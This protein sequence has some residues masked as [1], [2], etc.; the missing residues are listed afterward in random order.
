M[1]PIRVLVVEDSLTVRRRLVE[2]VDADAG[3]E[4]VGE[5]EDGQAAIELCQQLQPDVMTLDMVLPVMDGLATTEHVMAYCP[6]PILVVSSSAN[7]RDLFNTYDVL[8]AGALDVMEKP[9]GDDSNELWDRQLLSTLRLISRIKV[10]THPRARLNPMNSARQEA[11]RPAPIPARPATRSVRLVAL[12]ASTGGPGALLQVLKGLP[13]DF[14]VPILI[15]VHLQTAFATAFAEWLDENTPH[16]VCYARDGQRLDMPGVF[17]APADQHL[18]VRD[19]LLRLSHEAE[20]HFCRPS[21]DVMFES[22]ARECGATAAACLL[23][24]MGRDGASGLLEIRQAGGLTIAQD[25]ASCVVYGMPREAVLLGA[26][27]RILPL[28]AI[29]P[30]LNALVKGA[31]LSSP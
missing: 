2:V 22:I 4:V 13:A 21:V 23:T 10:I 12:G 25:E 27:S 31:Q 5:A 29:G 16:R 11:V 28:S 1:K 18:T 9:P 19:G 30:A 20:R 14:P 15:V 6:T 7:R 26:A 17:L 24:G 3:M 8:A